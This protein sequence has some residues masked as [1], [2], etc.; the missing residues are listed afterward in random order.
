MTAALLHRADI[1]KRR[2]TAAA[3]TALLG[4]LM[5]IT[6]DDRGSTLYVITL[7]AATFHAHTLE[8]LES[9]LGQ[10]EHGEDT[11]A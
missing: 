1:E 3:R 5:A 8:E 2:S 11:H 9:L 4:G 7:G 10:I 6:D